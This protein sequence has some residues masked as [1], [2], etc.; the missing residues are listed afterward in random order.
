MGNVVV[1]SSSIAQ[2]ASARRYRLRIRA[3]RSRT[4]MESW[5][6]AQARFTSEKTRRSS[7]PRRDMASGD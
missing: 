6:S 3:T 1:G 5:P 2:Y 4:P 7:V